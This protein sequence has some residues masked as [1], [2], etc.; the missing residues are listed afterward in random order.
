MP[1]RFACCIHPETP[2]VLDEILVF[3]PQDVQG[4]AVDQIAIFYRDA[5]GHSDGILRGSLIQFP[6]IQLIKEDLHLVK[7]RQAAGG[8]V[9][10]FTRRGLDRPESLAN[11]VQHVFLGLNGSKVDGID[12]SLLGR[13]C[14]AIGPLCIALDMGVS[15]D[16]TGNNGFALQVNTQGIG[17][18]QL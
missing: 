17:S 5:H 13:E 1:I 11:L 12:S 7:F 2:I 4:P 6:S 10:P 16:E 15:V 9:H 14:P 8:E 18:C 3:L